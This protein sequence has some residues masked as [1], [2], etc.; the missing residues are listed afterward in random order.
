MH[1]AKYFVNKLSIEEIENHP[2][3]TLSIIDCRVASRTTCS[4]GKS[5]KAKNQLHGAPLAG[6]MRDRNF[7]GHTLVSMSCCQP[8]LEEDIYLLNNSIS[9]SPFE[10]SKNSTPHQKKKIYILIL[11][12]RFFKIKIHFKQTF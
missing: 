7:H 2:I 10:I 1:L 4:I 12:K 3:P 11:G 6:M 8:K 5:G 9:L